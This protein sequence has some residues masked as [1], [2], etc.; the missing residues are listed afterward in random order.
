MAIDEDE[1]VRKGHGKKGKGR[2]RKRSAEDQEFRSTTRRR[3]ARSPTFTETTSAPGTPAP[4]TPS[5][6]GTRPPKDKGLANQDQ[7]TKEWLDKL[8]VSAVLNDK[9]GKSDL[10]QGKRHL[11]TLDRGGYQTQAVQMDARLKV[12]N[13]A[14]ML[15]K[16]E[17]GKINLDQ[18]K[19]TCFD[20][21]AAGL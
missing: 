15:T 4:G 9:V 2:G 19:V 12:C 11:A 16:D 1:A 7:K 10:Y 3:A 6:V 17:I 18:V 13:H 21:L 8:T 14:L 20:L 5:V